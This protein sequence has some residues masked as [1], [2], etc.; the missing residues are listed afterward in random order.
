MI[1]LTWTG[2][3]LT[4]FIVAVIWIDVWLEGDW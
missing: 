4:P 3:F 2:A 1:I